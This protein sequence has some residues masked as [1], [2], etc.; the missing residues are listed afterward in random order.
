MSISHRL[1]VIAKMFSVIIRPKL[2]KIESA[3]TDPHSV[4]FDAILDPGTLI[5]HNFD[6]VVPKVIFESFGTAVSD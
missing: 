4:H 1:A 3:P 5:T 2:R 6:L